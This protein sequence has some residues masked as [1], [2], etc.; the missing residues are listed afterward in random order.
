M[1]TGSVKWML[2]KVAP[3]APDGLVGC[4]QPILGI[5]AGRSIAEPGIMK[6]AIRFC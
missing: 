1:A 4:Q 3:P 2:G 5:G 6:I